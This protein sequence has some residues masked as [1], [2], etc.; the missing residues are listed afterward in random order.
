MIIGKKQQLWESPQMNETTECWSVKL[1]IQVTVAFVQVIECQ[2]W[3]DLGDV[4]LDTGRKER[5]HALAKITNKSHA[6]FKLGIWVLVHITRVSWAMER[7]W[8]SFEPSLKCL[9]LYPFLSWNPHQ[10]QEDTWRC[11][12]W[13]WW[14]GGEAGGG[15]PRMKKSKWYD[16]AKD[17]PNNPRYK[18]TEV[19]KK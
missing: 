12:W 3:G 9:I 19:L 18:G 4:Q 10:T 8:H 16:I 11:C 1:D 7:C 17:G 5:R 14:W 6:Y 2:A 13:W 15:N